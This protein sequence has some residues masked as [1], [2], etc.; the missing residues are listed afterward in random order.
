MG[1]IYEYVLEGLKKSPDFYDPQIYPTFETYLASLQEPAKYLWQ[2]YRSDRVE[3]DYSSPPVQAAYLIRYYTPHV[4]MTFEL[5]R[6]CPEL[7]SLPETINVSL[8]GAGPC[9]EVAGLALFLNQFCPQTKSLTVNVYDNAAD[10]WT[11]SRN[12][13]KNFVVN[14]LWK[15]DMADTVSKLDL[16]FPGVLKPI[17]ESI[18]NS[19]L[20]IFQNCL[21]EM[22]DISTAQYNLQFLLDRVPVNSA[23]VIG[24]LL[25]DQNRQ[26]VE[27]LG[28]IASKRSDCQVLETG[29]L[30]INL[31][32][33]PPGIVMNNLLT[34]G[35]P[36]LTARSRINVLFIVIYK[37]ADS[38]IN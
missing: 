5:L 3:V 18:S 13:T 15:G 29:E 36:Y 32:L 31:S 17:A 28:K 25:Y 4:K 34:G 11:P 35:E 26:I 37:G 10:K 6:L 27:Y 2:S 9:P 1:N 16:C 19:H 8:F 14:R 21:S 33:I 12:L 22:W 24:D 23:I 7:F 38:L 20:V 30:T